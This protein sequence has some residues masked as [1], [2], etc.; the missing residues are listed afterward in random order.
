[1]VIKPFGTELW[2]LSMPKKCE[3]LTKKDGKYYCTLWDH[4]RPDYCEI[5]PDSLFFCGEDTWEQMLNWGKRTCPLL[6]GL[7]LKDIYAKFSRQ[8]YISK[9]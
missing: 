5:Y 9:K 6:W 7:E 2:Q 3:K 1:L 4:E 8:K